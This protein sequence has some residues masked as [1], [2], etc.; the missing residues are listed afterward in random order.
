MKRK[1]LTPRSRPNA[2]R[3]RSSTG[4][5][6]L[7]KLSSV[8]LSTSRAPSRPIL[9][10]GRPLRSWR[11]CSRARCNCTGPPRSCS[12]SASALFRGQNRNVTTHLSV[13]TKK[14]SLQ[15]FSEPDETCCDEMNACNSRVCSFLYIFFFFS[16][17]ATCHYSE[18]D[19][20]K[21]KIWKEIY[22]KNTPSNALRSIRFFCEISKKSTA[23]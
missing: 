7:A 10:S 17:L 16:R 11:P 1:R 13:S 21:I 15:N 5:G 18:L 6:L 9:P 4:S 2:R 23:T 20:C 12:T 3:P 8:K 14:S 22:T 19:S